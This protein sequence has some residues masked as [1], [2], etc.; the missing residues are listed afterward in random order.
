[1]ISPTAMPLVADV[2]MVPRDTVRGGTVRVRLREVVSGGCHDCGAQW[3]GRA[4]FLMA[5]KH[6]KSTGHQTTAGRTVVY[7]YRP[8][9]GVR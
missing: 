4:A 2:G 5:T 1:M 9:G 3:S 6:T 7:T 8:I